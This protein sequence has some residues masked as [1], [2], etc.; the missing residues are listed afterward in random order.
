MVDFPV[1]FGPATDRWLVRSLRSASICAG[2]NK[3]FCT[4]SGRDHRDIPALRITVGK[5]YPLVA[6]FG[7]NTSTRRFQELFLIP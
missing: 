6:G 3:T 1:P 2:W 4:I 5:G 7:T